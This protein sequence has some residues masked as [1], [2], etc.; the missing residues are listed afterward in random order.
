MKK[1][2]PTMLKKILIT[3]MGGLLIATVGTTAA[4]NAG[5]SPIP[6][7]IGGEITLTVS[8]VQYGA[9]GDCVYT[10]VLQVLPSCTPNDYAYYDWEFTSTYDGPTSWPTVISGT[11]H[12]SGTT[13]DSF[14]ICP[15]FDS[16]GHLHRLPRRHVP[17]LQRLGDHHGV[18]L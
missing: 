1:T 11:G 12:F 7:P 3:A 16:P 8:D 18:R 17:Q 15:A 10:P 9:G 14:L 6:S 13:N 4:A 5:T 2:R